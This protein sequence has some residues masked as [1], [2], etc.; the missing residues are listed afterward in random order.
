MA[1]LARPQCLAADN[2]RF[3]DVVNGSP[4]PR[5]DQT[6]WQALD[7]TIRAWWDKDMV[8]ATEGNIRSSDSDTALFLPF[9]YIAL[10]SGSEK[11]FRSMFPFDAAF[12]NYALFAHGRLDVV[13][14]HI[15]N[16]LFMIERYGYCPN[17]NDTR[18][19]T[20]SQVNFV[21]NTI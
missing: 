19:S 3:A 13:L 14:N 9:P 4:P 18:V 21:P 7:A 11:A 17:A 20:R 1:A 10:G 5:L 2:A 15:L 8:R 16:Y 12:M 6:R